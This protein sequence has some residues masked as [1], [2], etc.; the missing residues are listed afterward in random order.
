MIVVEEVLKCRMAIIDYK[1]SIIHIT[2]QIGLI[3]SVLHMT[4]P[5]KY[6]FNTTLFSAVMKFQKKTLNAYISKLVLWH[7]STSSTTVF[8]CF[9]DLDS[10]TIHLY[11]EN[12][13]K[14]D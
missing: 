10:E 2:L 14:F 11:N 1:K 8:K 12:R 4:Y 9:N 7:L 3:D 13:K 5:T 6:K